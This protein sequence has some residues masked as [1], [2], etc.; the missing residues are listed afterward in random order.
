[1]K[2]K[3]FYNVFF[4]L[5][6]IGL[7]LALVACSETSTAGGTVD[8]NAVADYSADEKAIMESKVDS[9]KIFAEASPRN[10]D[11]NTIDSTDIW[12][13][14]AFSDVGE[15]YFSIEEYDPIFICYVRVHRQDFGVQVLKSVVNVGEFMQSFFMTANESG[16][17]Y[18]TKLDNDYHDAKGCEK[19]LLDF[20]HS[21]K[22]E[23]GTLYRHKA[24]CG[25]SNLHLTCSTSVGHLSNNIKAILNARAQTMKNLCMEDQ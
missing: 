15:V 1:M 22:N 2:N 24:D 19:D 3:P 8:D 11:E 12:Y 16:V 25:E 13:E 18:H 21:C 7:L 6:Y 9:I 10:I 4:F 5:A 23:G 14:V 17:V 20:E